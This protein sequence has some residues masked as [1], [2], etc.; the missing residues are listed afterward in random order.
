LQI[1]GHQTPFVYLA[2][3]VQIGTRVPYV[4][5]AIN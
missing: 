2:G 1:T 3:K 5:Y 4:H